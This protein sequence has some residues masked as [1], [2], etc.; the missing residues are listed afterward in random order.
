MNRRQLL[1]GIGTA[2]AAG[3]VRSYSGG[4]CEAVP[5]QVG[6][7]DWPARIAALPRPAAGEIVVTAVGDMIISNPATGRTAPDVQQQERVLRESDA[8]FGNCEEPIASVGF[9]YQKT[10]Q[11]ASPPILDDF[12]AAGFNMLS[13]ANNHYM[14]LG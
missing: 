5:A 11:M 4:G 14:D 10:S 7:P 8:A 3:V 2:A 13:G 1:T 6:P 9:M 12:K